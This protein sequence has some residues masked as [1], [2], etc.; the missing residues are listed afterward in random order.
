MRCLQRRRGVLRVLLAKH[1]HEETSFVEQMYNFLK[2]TF[3][4]AA[5]NIKPRRGYLF[6]VYFY[7]QTLLVN[8]KGNSLLF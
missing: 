2:I 6:T 5:T 4:L 3:Y 1:F 8:I 7:E